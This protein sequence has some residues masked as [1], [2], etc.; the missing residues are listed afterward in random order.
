MNRKKVL[1]VFTPILILLFLIGIPVINV[2]T[3]NGQSLKRGALTLVGHRGAAGLAPE[4]TL[5]AI[6]RGISARADW[7]EIDIRQTKDGKIIVMHDA[8]VDRTTSGKGRVKDLTY[9]EIRSLK[10]D[11]QQSDSTVHVPLLTEVMATVA[12]A[13]KRLI[14]EIKNPEDHPGMV[15]QLIRILEAQ[16]DLHNFTV[17][18]FNVD[19]VVE[20]KHK[21]PSISTGIFCLGLGGLSAYKDIPCDYICPM[22]QSLLFRPGLVKKIHQ[23]NKKVFVWTPDSKWAISYA[24]KKGVDGII[25]DRP[26]RFNE[27]LER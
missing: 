19:A 6:N 20:L 18:S 14:I 7:V 27:V 17:F 23:L 26:D 11:A 1:A 13:N 21:L 2:L 9:D 4:N 3:A 22:W 5:A 12:K 10:L 25:T 8:R 24:L 16:P 15:Q